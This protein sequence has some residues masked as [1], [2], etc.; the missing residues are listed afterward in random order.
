MWSIPMNN[1]IGNQGLSEE[2]EL[3]LEEGDRSFANSRPEETNRPKKR[4][5][6]TWLY[7]L[8]CISA[9]TAVMYLAS[10][11]HMWLDDRAMEADK[12]LEAANMEGV[13]GTV[14]EDIPEITYTQEELDA[15]IAVAVEKGREE[16]AVLEAERILGGIESLLTDGYTAV[17][18]LRPF[19]TDD[20]VI[21]SGGKFNFIPIRHDLRKNNLFQENLRILE[22]GELQYMDGET[23]ISHKG[24]DISRHQG[25]ID[26]K[27]VGETDVEFVFIRVGYR[28]YG[29]GNM[30]EDEKF[31][32]NIK[33]ALN[34]GLKVGVYYFSQAIGT[35]EALEEAQFVLKKIAPY[36]VELPVVIDVE[37][38]SDSGG[39]MNLISVEERTNVALTFCET[40]E[41]GGYTPMIY[42]N[43]E[44]G[45]MLIDLEPLEKYEK[46]FAYYGKVIYYP[47]DYQVWQYSEKGSVDGIKGDVDLNISLKMWGG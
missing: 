34:A 17:E 2:L 16:G 9:L 46:W 6:R 24:I 27:K 31:E 1:K 3:Q 40:I 10:L 32:N 22:T 47:Y 26:W 36:K 5:K 19:Y 33:G 20:L 38:V 35:V 42:H 41:A 8:G 21:V 14:A 7:L 30:M 39:R 15:L 37:R 13:S 45:V 44:M 12:T 23:V 43:M 11:I 29:N 28:G 18:A 4:K 25:D